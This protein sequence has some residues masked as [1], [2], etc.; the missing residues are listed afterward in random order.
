M[1]K[2]NYEKQILVTSLIIGSLLALTEFIMAIITKSQ[3][4]LTDAA[5]DSTD[6]IVSA[7]TLFLI[8][9]YTKPISEK[10]PFGFLQIESVFIALRSF[11]LLAISLCLSV[12]SLQIVLNGGNNIK[13][14]SISIFQLFLCVINLIVF[15]ILNKKNK[16]ISSPTASLEVYGWKLDVF[17][18][19]GMSFAFFIAKILEKTSF[20]FILPYFDQIIAIAITIFMLP[21]A[22]KVL[23]EGVRSVF[24]FAPDKTITSKIKDC[25]NYETQNENIDISFLDIIKTGRK[26]W[27]SL[28]FYPKEDTISMNRLKQISYNCNKKL[29]EKFGDI[30]FEMIPEIKEK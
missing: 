30:Y 7:I 17:Y 23:R 24:L 14:G 8:P 21:E 6:M 27:V 2:N 22:L 11:M 1:K 13:S 19:L 5:Y 4:V 15:I 12:N 25:I 29:N 20:N 28:Y 18:S 26:I 10:R 3:S 16:K 9:L